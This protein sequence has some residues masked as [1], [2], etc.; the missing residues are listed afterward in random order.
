MKAQT[1]WDVR[2]ADVLKKENELCSFYLWSKK[3]DSKYW[4]QSQGQRVC[5]NSNFESWKA[6]MLPVK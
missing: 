6:E 5:R 4:S 1:S 3:K 2:K